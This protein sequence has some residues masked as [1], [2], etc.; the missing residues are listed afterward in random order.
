M[1]KGF[2]LY[3]LTLVFTLSLP[4][5]GNPSAVPVAPADPHSLEAF[6]KIKEF[7]KVSRGLPAFKIASIEN[8]E[9]SHFILQTIHLSVDGYPEISMTLKFPKTF[10][11]P[12]S[13]LVLF[14]G[15][16]TGSE[17][18]NLVGDPENSVY[19]G[20][21]Y[22][23][24]FKQKNGLVQW[25]WSRMQMIPLLMSV[26][27]AWLH[28]QPYIDRTKINVVTVSFGT[29]FYPLAQRFLNDQGLYS[30]T[31]VFG[32]G[33]VDIP[34]VIG[35][36][37]AKKMGANELEVSKVVIRQQ[38]WFL[39]P[40]YHV[41]HLKGPFLVVNGETDT[42]FPTPSKAGLSDNLAEPKKVVSLPGGHIQPDK[43]EIIEAFMSEVK[44]FLTENKA[45]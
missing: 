2:V 40:R 21:Q 42:V 38:T 24:P 41:A 13:A 12:I 17:A 10:R 27:L 44:K 34:E 45:L 3:L 8:K 35:G 5:L 15:F 39:E 36:E 20:F 43:P 33:G 1:K 30:K 22:P 11:P 31:T 14:T 29:L 9:S 26:G 4:V 23:W 28:Q 32:Y 19:I 7:Y 18:I 16:Q 6:E 37:L 25:D